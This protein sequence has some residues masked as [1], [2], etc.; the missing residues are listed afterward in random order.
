[1][2]KL[3]QTFHSKVLPVEIR[4]G[5]VEG[6]FFGGAVLGHCCDS[7]PGSKLLHRLCQH[8]HW[9]HSFTSPGLHIVAEEICHSVNQ[10]VELY[11]RHKAKW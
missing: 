1:M 9:F 2:C 11:W 10:W 4:S 6:L 3:T 8:A 5:E 7:V